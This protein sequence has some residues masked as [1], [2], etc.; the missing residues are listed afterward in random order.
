MTSTFPANA[1]AG[2]AIPG[3]AL[4]VT[5]LEG[6]EATA[7]ALATRLN[8]TIEIASTRNAACRLLDRRSWSIVVLD[9]LFADA[10][11][12]GADLLWKRT[13][14]AIPLQ[15]NFGL[16]GADRLEREIHAALARR[17]R[18]QELAA[19]VA[20]ANLDSDLRNAVTG[21]LLESQL[22]LAEPDI[23]P[24]LEGHLR[25]LA[26]IADRMRSHLGNPAHGPTTIGVLPSRA[27]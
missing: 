5:A 25:T 4:I 18:E 19:A 21:F 20:W 8:L 23:P 26:S 24:H 12:E 13:G 6:I 17:L 14:L 9:Q 1:G 10:D 16:A 11:P 22:A 3:A 2:M 15:I 27:N 7:A